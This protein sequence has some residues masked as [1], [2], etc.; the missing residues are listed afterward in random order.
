MIKLR[1]YQQDIYNKTKEAFKKGYKAP[2][3]V[4]PCRS[5]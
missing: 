5:R 2:L 3:I 1:D 4:L